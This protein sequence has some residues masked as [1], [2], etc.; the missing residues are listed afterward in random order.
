M[1]FSADNKSRTLTAHVTDATGK[2]TTS[3]RVYDRQ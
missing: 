2:K 1:A 3:V